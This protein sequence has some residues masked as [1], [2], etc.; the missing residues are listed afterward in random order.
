MKTNEEKYIRVIFEGGISTDVTKE[1]PL[2]FRFT[3]SSEITDEDIRGA[4]VG[5]IRKIEDAL[6]VRV[7][8][9]VTDLVVN[10]GVLRVNNNREVAVRLIVNGGYSY[11]DDGYAFLTVKRKWN[12]FNVYC[13]ISETGLTGWE[14]TIVYS[15]SVLLYENERI[16]AVKIDDGNCEAELKDAVSLREL[17]PIVNRAG[18]L[19]IFETMNSMIQASDETGLDGSLSKEIEDGDEF[20]FAC[21][22][23]WIGAAVTEGSFSTAYIAKNIEEDKQ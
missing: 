13:N 1:C 2:S 19:G 15:E 8:E 14:G 18:I 21:H 9:N 6:D 5:Y 3:Q 16:I 22:K 17:R 10:G 7:P 11:A 4:V 20:R 12:G 23:N